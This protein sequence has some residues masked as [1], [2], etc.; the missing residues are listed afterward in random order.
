M[1]VLVGDIPRAGGR[2]QPGILAKGEDHTPRTPTRSGRPTVRPTRDRRRKTGID[3]L[4]RPQSGVL[5]PGPTQKPSGKA[6]PPGPARPRFGVGQD[7]AS[8]AKT[9]GWAKV[10][11]SIGGGWASRMAQ[12]RQHSRN[13]PG[14]L[15][16]RGSSAKFA[17]RFKKLSRP[18][19]LPTVEIGV[20]RPPRPASSPKS[21][22]GFA[23]DGPSVRDRGPGSD[24]QHWIRHHL[25]P[26]Q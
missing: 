19:G 22:P 21:P 2:I 7:D 24:R 23:I 5:T 12:S 6:S 16:T 10:E 20:I 14:F 26:C 1:R 4:T 13:R 9:A 17:R 3:R 18:S 11:P 25:G 8:S 15:A